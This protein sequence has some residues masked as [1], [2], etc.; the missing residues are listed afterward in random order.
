MCDYNKNKKLIDD[1]HKRIYRQNQLLTPIISKLGYTSFLGQSY[2]DIKQLLREDETLLDFTDYKSDEEVQQFACFVVDK[3]QAYPKLVKSFTEEGIKTLLRGRPSDFLYKEPYASKAVNMIWKPLAKEVKGKRTIYYVPSG[4]MHKIA[5]ESLPLG[6]GS[7]LGDHYDFVRLTSAR[8]IVKF[9]KAPHTVNYTTAA[10]YGALKYTMD[11]VSMLREASRYK[12]ESL[13]AFNRGEAARGNKQ[14]KELANTKEEIDVIRVIL[15]G[16]HLKV[17]AKTGTEGTEESFLAM[18]GNAPQLLHIATHG[19]FY[20]TPGEAEDVSYL[21][22]Y[23]D[24]MQLSGLIMA[25]G[26]RAWIG[27]KI[28]KG[29]Q[30]GVLT[31]NGIAAMDLSETDLVVLSACKTGLGI[32]TS[33]GVFGLQRAFKK[34]GAQTLI[35]SLWN[36]DDEAAKDFMIKFYQELADGRNKWNKRKAFEKAKAFVRSKTYIR[37][38]KYYKGDPY[39]WAGFVMLD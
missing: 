9:R 39:Y 22:G 4:I 32:T 30:D 7:L 19:F 28:P 38:G 8:E 11:T 6:D 27:Q 37:K 1:L 13:L 12:I 29:I 36:V 16:R 3:K 26:N 23:Y 24:A 34:A 17:S 5:L 21:K 31:A 14:F 2:R 33:D 15:K 35:M 20:D 18:S 25:G 10:L